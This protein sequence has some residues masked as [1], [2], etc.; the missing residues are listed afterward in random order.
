MRPYKI[1]IPLLIIF[2]L[3]ACVDQK[4]LS[5]DE[6]LKK[7]NENSAVELSDTDFTVTKSDCYAYSAM[8]D[9]VLITLYTADDGVVEQCTVTSKK[10]DF[11]S[12]C[13]NII[14][15]YTGFSEKKSRDFFKK[16]GNVDGFHLFVNSYDVGKTMILNRSDNELNT[17]NLPTLKREVKEEDIA[18]PTLPDTTESS[19][20]IRQ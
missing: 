12:I 10:A 5:V 9:G 13:L 15:T 14:H 16:G 20:Y 8:L 19:D 3:T 2:L 4:Q 1:I 18:R 17:N 6:F 11:D 7:Y